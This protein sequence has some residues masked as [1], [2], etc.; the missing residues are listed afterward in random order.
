MK[1][2][3]IHSKHL[4][5]LRLLFLPLLLALQGCDTNETQNTTTSELLGYGFHGY[6]GYDAEPNPSYGMGFLFIQ[7]LGH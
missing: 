2:D 1:L 4:L 3:S 6:V 5:L 7:P